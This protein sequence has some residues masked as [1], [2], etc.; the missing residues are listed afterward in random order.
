[1]RFSERMKETALDVRA[2]RARLLG[3]VVV[4]GD[5]G[6]DEARRAWN[7]AVDQRPAAV[8]FPETAGDVAAIVEFARSNGLR[9]APQGTGHAASP[10]LLDDSVLVKTSRMRGV[11][12]DAAGRRA[13]VEAGALWIEVTTAAAEHGLAALAGSAPTVG[14]VGYTLGGG[15]GWLGRRYGFAANSVQAVELV[16]ADGRLIKADREHHADLFWALRGGGGSFGVVTAIEFALYPVRDVYAGALFWPIERSREILRAWRKWVQDVPNEVSSVGRI[17]R[18]PA[19][20]A[21]PEPLRGGAFVLVEAAYLGGEAD[22]ADLL[23]P[24]RELAP[25]IDTFSVIPVTALSKLHMD[26]EQPVAGLGDGVLLERLPP[27]AVDAFVAA[28]GPRSRSSLVSVEL[29]HLGGALAQASP[30]HGAVGSFDEPFALFAVGSAVDADIAAS[31]KAQL[32]LVRGVMAPWSARRT[33]LNFTGRLTDAR[34][35]YQSGAYPRLRE[36]K[37]AYD[38]DDRIRSN[39]PI[40]P[41]RQGSPR[42]PIAIPVRR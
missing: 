13:R 11:R 30:E 23:R 16:T 39:S 14:V 24:L 33:F 31:V 18:F 1:M 2:L 8:A 32:R 42:R 40:P 41:A 5:E 21:V 28:A 25:E 27:E 36:V 6:W 34:S 38:P 4:P 37:S 26:P 20:P 12:I 29:R 35:H 19:I 15:L 9:V 10:G 3:E 7:L 22:G 17:M